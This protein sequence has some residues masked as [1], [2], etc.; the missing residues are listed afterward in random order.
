MHG[1][2]STSPDKSLATGLSEL[3][4]AANFLTSTFD[5]EAK[6]TLQVKGL[7]HSL[8]VAGYIRP[9]VDNVIIDPVYKIYKLISKP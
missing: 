6:L 5:I 7:C 8:S 2:M 3:H 4:R 1:L 9:P